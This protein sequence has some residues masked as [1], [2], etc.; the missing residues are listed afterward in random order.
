MKKILLLS[1]LT[2]LFAFGTGCTTTQKSL[3]GAVVGGAAG[4]G[5]GEHKGKEWEMAGIG[6]VVGAAG[7]AIYDLSGKK[8]A[9][10]AQPVAQPS[11][12]QPQYT[13]P[14]AQPYYGDTE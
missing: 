5:L 4:A 12:P 8:S 10:Q 9:P 7:T 6:A 11:Q 2:G 13:P 1:V 3:V 14:P